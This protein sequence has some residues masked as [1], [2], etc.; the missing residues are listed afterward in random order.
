MSRAPIHARDLR[1]NIKAYGYEQGT[2]ITLELLLDEFVEYRQRMQTLAE[3]QSQLIDQLDTVMRISE[4]MKFRLE[5]LKRME[6]QHD[7]TRGQ[8]IIPEN[9]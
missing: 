2:T 9:E 1:A 7:E 6:Q 5:H 8:G 4:G 3:I